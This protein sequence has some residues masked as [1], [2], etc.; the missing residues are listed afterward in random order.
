MLNYILR[1]ILFLIPIMLGVSIIVFA[2]ISLIP[3]DA[4][5]YI[6][7]E[8]ATPEGLA[9]LRE[10]LG[11]NDPLP[12]QY[13]NFLQDVLRGDFGRSL[14]SNEKV[15]VE[16]MSRFP[17][18]FELTVISMLLAVLVGIPVGILAAT[19]Q[20]SIFDTITLF[21]A[22]I[23]ISMPIFWLGLMMIWLFSLKL[24]WL[25]PSGRISVG[26]ELARITNLYIVDAL[27]QGNWQ[28]LKDVLSH[29]ILPGIALGTIPMA[30]IVRMTRSSILEVL[31]QDFIRTAYAKGLKPRVV[32]FKHALKNA[33]IPV[34]TTIGLQFGLLLG[35][36]VLTETIFSWPG[37]GRLSY[38]AIMSRDYP[39]VQGAVLLLAF[40]FVIVNLLVDLS[41]AIFDPRIRYK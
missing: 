12:V 8:H 1:R 23:G 17:A 37:I 19:K 39:V 6:L 20:Y 32:I 30:I 13:Y 7:G 29:I 9:Q 4:A 16:V 5:E 18:T 14:I 10:E 24:G 40:T 41:Y 3:G 26:I 25:P 21:G 15:T 33:L 28:A 2:M 27:V 36:A 22:L 11:L 34:V 38:D 35:G 31:K